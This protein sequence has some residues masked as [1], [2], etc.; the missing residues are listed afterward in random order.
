MIAI[1]M[2]LPLLILIAYRF[3]FCVGLLEHNQLFH[4]RPSL[5]EGMTAYVVYICGE[6][7]V[8]RR[9]PSER[10][11]SCVMSGCDEYLD[12]TIYNRI[13]NA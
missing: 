8:L 12:V 11:V 13:S 4:D 2:F 5:R 1:E 3:V 6:S 10:S 7:R 9:F